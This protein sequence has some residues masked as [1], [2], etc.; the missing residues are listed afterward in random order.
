MVTS[1]AED[2][3]QSLSDKLKLKYIEAKKDEVLL[4]VRLFTIDRAIEEFQTQR[5]EMEQE[6][7]A[8]K[9]IIAFIEELLNGAPDVK[10]LAEIESIVQ[11]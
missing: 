6:L 9:Y 4:S 10:E 11:Y 5:D 2:K 7:N 8:A 1:K 3:N